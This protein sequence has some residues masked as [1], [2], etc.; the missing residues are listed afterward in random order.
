MHSGGKGGS[1]SHGGTAGTGFSGGR[2]PEATLLREV[3]GRLQASQKAAWGGDS[4]TT[5][6]D[7]DASRHPRGARA[8]SRWRGGAA[9]VALTPAGDGPRPAADQAPRS[10]SRTGH[11]ALNGAR[12]ET[13]RP[14]GSSRPLW[15]VAMPRAVGISLVVIGSGMKNKFVRVGMVV[16][17]ISL[18]A[19]A[20]LA[21]EKGQP[22]PSAGIAP[23]PSAPGSGEAQERRDD[24]RDDR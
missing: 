23:A 1:V 20:A 18:S 7:D 8:V 2:A 13:L 9:R 15:R 10:P 5:A 24:S 12:G 4:E 19:G 3:R 21:E 17:G 6:P 14:G 16:F 22:S 11:R